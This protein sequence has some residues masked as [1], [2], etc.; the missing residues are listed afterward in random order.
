MDLLFE[1]KTRTDSKPALLNNK[2]FDFYNNSNWDKV[3]KIRNILNEWYLKFPKEGKKDLKGRFIK[4]FDSAFFELFVFTLFEKN[5]F[6]IEVHPELENSSSQPDFLIR[7]DSLELYVEVKVTLG[8][9]EESIAQNNILNALFD[10]IN[11]NRFSG[12]YLSIKS[13]KLESTNQ[14]S[15]K[16]IIK[17]M[18]E[19][20]LSLKDNSQKKEFC[21]NDKDIS[22]RIKFIPIEKYDSNLRPIS[23]YPSK[24]WWGSG[25]TNLKKKIIDK[26]K[27]YKQLNKPL[28]L[29]INTLDDKTWN[30]NDID[31]AILGTSF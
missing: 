3:E 8:E 5:G 10:K 17:F 15:A 23:I 27:K 9:S 30:T 11:E 18:H 4:S 28:L 7:K 20:H 13:A 24:S 21:Y 31:S 29:F 26:S 12:Y 25:E 16:K 1:Q 2:T 22:L 19:F 6:K 14:P